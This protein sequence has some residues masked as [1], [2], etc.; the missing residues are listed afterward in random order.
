MTAG[1]FGEVDLDLLADYI[2]GVLDGTPE[3]TAVAHLIDADPSWARAYTSLASAV[4]EVQIQ[5]TAWGRQPEPMPADVFDRLDTTLVDQGLMVGAADHRA[6]TATIPAD[7][8]PRRLTVVSDTAPRGA[9]EPVRRRRWSRW[10]G[11][12]TVAAAVV[13]FAGFGASQIFDGG[14]DRTA[15]VV[16]ADAASATSDTGSQA[17]LA[18]S[19]A[20]RVMATGTDYARS[21]IADSIPK[22]ATTTQVSPRSQRQPGPA[23]AGAGLGSTVPG[24]ERLADRAARVVCLAAVTAAYGAGPLVVDLVDYAS[25]EGSPALVIVFVDR[26]GERWVWVVGPGCGH[27]PSVADTRYRT[28]VG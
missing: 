14:A 11:P 27:P 3:A 24:L 21:T 1:Q 7:Q 8:A 15:S 13:V 5:L 6:T 19:S 23:A 9:I 22:S 18:E 25:F 2:G 26:A 20:E 4:G 12:V 28:R 10:A 17:A 16:S